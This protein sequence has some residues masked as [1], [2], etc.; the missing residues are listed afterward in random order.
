[1]HRLVTTVKN[2]TISYRIDFTGT[3][4]IYSI[5]RTH[6][7][8]NLAF[9]S[10]DKE[11]VGYI[12]KVQAVLYPAPNEPGRVRLVDCSTNGTIING[13][14]LVERKDDLAKII[15]QASADG[16]LENLSKDGK[17]RDRL[18]LPDYVIPLIHDDSSLLDPVSWLL[19]HDDKIQIGLIVLNYKQQTQ[20][21]HDKPTVIE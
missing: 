21:I 14:N 11:I 4:P 5:G 17:L 16:L 7:R 2:V 18:P 20:E 6:Y 19:E 15:R 13:N 12:S 1:M 3:P 9:D 8:N 10:P